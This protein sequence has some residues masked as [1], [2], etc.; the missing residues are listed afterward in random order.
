MTIGRAV[1]RAIPQDPRDIDG[2]TVWLQSDRGVV[3]DASGNV[4]EWRDQSGRGN[5][6]VQAAAGNRPT[7][8]TVDGRRAVRTMSVAI[9]GTLRVMQIPATADTDPHATL[10]MSI[11][12]AYRSTSTAAFAYVLA[13]YPAVAADNNWILG[14]NLTLATTAKFIMTETGTNTDRIAV[15]GDGTTGAS[16]VMAGRYD[17]TGFLRTDVSGAAGAPVAIAG[18]KSTSGAT[19]IGCYNGSG[20]PFDGDILALIIVRRYLAL[21]GAD[22]VFMRDYLRR[23]TGAT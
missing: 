1:L 10:G 12:A 17:P 6:A 18:V 16:V 11:Y 21:G 8:V 3:L 4:S 22:D 15:D 19:W 2:L 9:G 7:Y 5:H 14:A 13:K 20:A 23:T